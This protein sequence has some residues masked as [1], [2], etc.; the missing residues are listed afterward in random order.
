[1]ESVLEA[2]RSKEGDNDP[3][4]QEAGRNRVQQGSSFTDFR[5]SSDGFY[6][7]REQRIMKKSQ[8]NDS[9][10][11]TSTTTTTTNNNSGNNNSNKPPPSPSNG[12]TI[13]RWHTVKVVPSAAGASGNRC[14]DENDNDSRA[15]T[16]CGDGRCFTKLCRYYS[17]WPCHRMPYI[18]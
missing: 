1:M 14:D 5:S 16:Y 7:Y 4:S 6:I 12:Y 17:E 9:T 18:C 3:N 2:D 15:N 10:T 13:R 8:R 11:V